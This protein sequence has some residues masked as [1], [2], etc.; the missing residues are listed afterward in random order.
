MNFAS[1]LGFE[2]KELKDKGFEIFDF[3]KLTLL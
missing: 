1:G 3:K 2:D